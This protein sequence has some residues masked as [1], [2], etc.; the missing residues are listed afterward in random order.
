MVFLWLGHKLVSKQG[1]GSL[2]F[3]TK[4]FSDFVRFVKVPEVSLRCFSNPKLLHSPSLTWNVK[5]MVFKRNLLF[6]GTIFR[7]HVELWEGK[8]PERSS[9]SKIETCHVWLYPQNPPMEG[10]TI[11][12]YQTCG[13]LNKIPTQKKLTNR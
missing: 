12:G 1:G 4:T 3:L 8:L 2:I 5:M 7:F 13:A 11:F 9:V 6:Q 10:Q